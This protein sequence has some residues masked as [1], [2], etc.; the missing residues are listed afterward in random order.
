MNFE[1]KAC[2]SSLKIFLVLTL[3][4]FPFP[5]FSEDKQVANDEAQVIQT[6]ISDR[7]LK[8]IEQLIAIAQRKSSQ[9]QEARNAMGLGAFTDI[10]S[11]EFLPSQTTTNSTLPDILSVS[12]NSFSITMTIDPIKVLNSIRQLPMREARWHEAKQQKR[13]SVVQHYL[14]YLQARQAKKIATYRMQQLALA[15]PKTERIA[16][17][18][19]QATS[20]NQVSY[21]GNP[22]YV[23]AAMDMLNTNARERLALE[24]LAACVGLS[25]QATITL[26]EY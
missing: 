16:S 13:V 22:D 24:E 3:I 10:L 11:V 25:S 9:V 1:S 5:T 14:A 21:L 4:S 19:S 23:A 20:R 2:L 18:N 8:I 7:D 6:N 17:L 12:E 26:V 15:K